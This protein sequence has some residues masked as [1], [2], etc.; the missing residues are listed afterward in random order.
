MSFPSKFPDHDCKHCGVTIKKGDPVHK[1]D[2]TGTW[3]IN[4]NCP[5]PPVKKIEEAKKIPE[6]KEIIPGTIKVNGPFDEAEL[7]V[8][9][10]RDRAY[11]MVMIEVD[12]YSKLTQP[13]KNSLG[14][15]EGMLTRALVDTTIELMKIHGIKSNYGADAFD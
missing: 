7:I 8:K 10:A 14:Q 1:I 5:N 3:C 12:D 9:W 2:K 13:E 4:T 6:K 15:K 11:K